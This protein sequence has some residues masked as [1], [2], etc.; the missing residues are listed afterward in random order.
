VV[1]IRDSQD[2]TFGVSLGADDYGY[3]VRVLPLEIHPRE[4]SP[5]GVGTVYRPLIG[6]SRDVLVQNVVWPVD[7]RRDK[8]GIVIYTSP[9]GVC[10]AAR[11]SK[12]MRR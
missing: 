9:D 5:D 8:Q 6:Q 12:K 2:V 7:Y 3:R 1:A 4:P 11:S 10:E